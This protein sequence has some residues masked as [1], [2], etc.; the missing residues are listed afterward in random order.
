MN[1]SSI[2]KLKIFIEELGEITNLHTV[3]L[4]MSRTVSDKRGV[5]I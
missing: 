4:N 5:H 2:L 3:K 1:C